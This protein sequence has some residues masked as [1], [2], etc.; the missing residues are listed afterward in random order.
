M[1]SFA[2]AAS[3]DECIVSDNMDLVPFD[4]E[5]VMFEVEISDEARDTLQGIVEAKIREAFGEFGT[6][7][8]IYV[9]LWGGSS[10]RDWDEIFEEYEGDD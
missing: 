9:E 3:V 8:S 2:W 5:S 4:R 6:P 1:E 7:P 10:G